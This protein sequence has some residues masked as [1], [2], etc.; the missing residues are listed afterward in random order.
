MAAHKNVLSF[1]SFEQALVWAK[2]FGKENCHFHQTWKVE[3]LAPAKYA[4]GVFSK[5]TGELAG[6]AE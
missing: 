2:K 3:K 5:N 4:V 1:N 6:Y